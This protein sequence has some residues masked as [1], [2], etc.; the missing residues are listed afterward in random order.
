MR[1]RVSELCC[2]WV[3]EPPRYEMGESWCTLVPGMPL[4]ILPPCTAGM[5]PASTYHRV[6]VSS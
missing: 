1:V 4:V 3:M 2:T 5:E 6:G